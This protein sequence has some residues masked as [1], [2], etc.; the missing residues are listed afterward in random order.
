MFA[1]LIE[2]L[3]AGATDGWFY[4]NATMAFKKPPEKTQVP[5][6]VHQN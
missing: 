5:D 6:S 1:S 2:N 4:G 3:V